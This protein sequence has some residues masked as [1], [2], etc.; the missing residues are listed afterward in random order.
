LRTTD[1]GSG[2]NL[3]VVPTTDQLMLVTFAVLKSWDRL[4]STVWKLL[5][6]DLLSRHIQ[7]DV[8]YLEADGNSIVDLEVV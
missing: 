6:T 1:P 4:R 5:A 7:N 2:L 8:E 3:L